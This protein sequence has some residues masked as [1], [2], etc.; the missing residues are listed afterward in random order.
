MWRRRGPH[1]PDTQMS[2]ERAYAHVADQ[3]PICQQGSLSVAGFASLSV[4]LKTSSARRASRVST[5]VSEAEDFVPKVAK[6]HPAAGRVLQNLNTRESWV[7]MFC[8]FGRER[9]GRR[10]L[11]G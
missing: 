4:G 3:M 7:T 11:I 6:P 9:R 5:G 1:H 10:N 2:L 8:F